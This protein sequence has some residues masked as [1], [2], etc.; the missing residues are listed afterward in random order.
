MSREGSLEAPT[1]HP[2]DWQNPDFLNKDLLDAEMERQF[3]VCHGCRRC[4]NICGSFPKLFDLVDESPTGELD[5]VS[6]DAYS[7]IVDDC[8]LCDMCYLTKCPYVPP[9]PFNIDFPHLMLRYKAYQHQAGQTS[10]IKEQLSQ[11]DRNS[12]LFGT[13]S[14]VV[15]YVNAVGSPARPALEAVANIDQRASIPSFAGTTLIKELKK[16][17]LTRNTAGIAAAEKAVLYATCYGNYNEVQIGHAAARILAHL[18]VD[19]RVEY[20]GCCGMPQLEQGNIPRVAEGALRIAAFFEPLIDE[21]RTILALIPSCALMIKSEWPGLHPDAHAITKL[22]DNTQDISEYISGLFAKYGTPPALQSLDQNLTL[23]VACHA[24]AQNIG[25]KAAE[26]LRA[27][28]NT[29]VTTIERCSGHGGT[30]GMMKP[31]FDTALK[32]GAPVVTQVQKSPNA[33]FSSE[34]PL[35]AEHIRQGLEMKDAQALQ[36]ME[37][38]HPLEILARALGV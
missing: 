24:R 28:P 19:I 21:G 5:S 6:K 31:H 33:I 35:A 7:T 30:W 38:L 11:V 12:K 1:R 17:P 22:R 29:A 3:D 13:I 8:T 32:I 23:H 36:A 18:G 15:N 10:F 16:N 37:K 9:H 4:F 2:L 26:M 27:I 34:C 25:V 14:P 20:P